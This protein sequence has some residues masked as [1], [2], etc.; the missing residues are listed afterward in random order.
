AFAIPVG[1]GDVHN[2]GNRQIP[3]LMHG[4]HAAETGAGDGGAV[5][6]IDAADDGLLLRLALQ[7]P[8]ATHHA[9]HGVVGLRAGAGEEHVVHVRRSLLGDG[10]GQ[11][12]RRRV[13]ALEEAVVVG[14]F[15][16]LPVRGVGQ[17]GAAVADVDAPEAG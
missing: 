9:H 14:Q 17:L 12:H 3:L 6:T 16:H 2:A 4:G 10:A 8:V 7:V 15:E 11:L 13:G 1:L 5:V